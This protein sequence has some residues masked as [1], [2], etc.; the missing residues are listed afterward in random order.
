M[1]PP[2]ETAVLF[3]VLASS[4]LP[5]GAL[6]GVW[7]PP[8]RRVT[9]ALLAFASGALV[10]AVAFELFED[11]FHQNA[12]SA[13]V[14]F[15]VGASTFVLVDTWLDRRWARRSAAGGAVGLA[16]REQRSDAARGH[17][18]RE[19]PGGDRGLREDA[20]G[21][22]RCQGRLAHLVRRGASPGSGCRR[23]LRWAARSL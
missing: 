20:R 1:M 15:A 14:A 22:A 7:R 16:H 5:L 11:A 18:R 2:M 3:A 19:P 21:R 13:G 17:L 8:A 6:L 4:A 10:T 23:R 12:W 9:A